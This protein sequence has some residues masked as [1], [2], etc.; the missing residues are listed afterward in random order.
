MAAHTSTTENSQ[1]VITIVEDEENQPLAPSA[2]LPSSQTCGPAPDFLEAYECAKINHNWHKVSSSL[3]IHPE[4]LT[5][6]PG[7]L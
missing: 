4:W 2:Q 5:T 3:V 6:I 7:G 1:S